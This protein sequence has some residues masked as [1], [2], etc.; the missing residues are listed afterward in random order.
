MKLKC[1]TIPFYET[2]ATVFRMIPMPLL[3]CYQFSCV[4]YSLLLLQPNVERTQNQQLASKPQSA[5][6]IQ[7]QASTGTGTLGT[8]TSQPS[9]MPGPSPPPYSPPKYTPY[10]TYQK[11]YQQPYYQQPYQQPYYQQPYQQQPYRPAYYQQPPYVAPPMQMMQQQTIQVQTGLGMLT[12]GAQQ[13]AGMQSS[14]MNLGSTT[15]GAAPPAKPTAYQPSKPTAYQPTKPTAYA[16]TKNK[17]KK[18]KK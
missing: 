11:P 6:G 5:N 3:G 15:V 9:T 7:S 12:V 17:G 10:P 2:V 8:Q 14:Y 18:S 16:P 13:G 1:L 4:T